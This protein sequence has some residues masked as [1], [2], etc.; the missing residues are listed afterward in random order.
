MYLFGIVWV[1]VFV[2]GIMIF[3]LAICSTLTVLVDD[4]LR[5]RF[6][7]IGVIKKS[8]PLAEIVSVTTVTNPWYYGWG[9]HWT[10]HGLLYNVSGYGAVEVR[11]LS[12]RMFRIGTDEPEVL[13]S[14]IE[15][16]R[17]KKNPG[18]SGTELRQG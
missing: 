17:A 14:A 13:R 16:A 6:G 9:I 18:I 4:T 3:V 5:I 7:P 10:P 15:Q 2:L 11:L 1:A 12:G 8:W